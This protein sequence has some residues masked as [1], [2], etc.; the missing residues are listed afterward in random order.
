MYLKKEKGLT[1]DINELGFA[2][3][4]DLLLSINNV[5][6]ELRGINHPFAVYESTP[7]DVELIVSM[8]T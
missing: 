7:K 4:K 6:V 8:L 3:L 5:Y 2:K 1:L